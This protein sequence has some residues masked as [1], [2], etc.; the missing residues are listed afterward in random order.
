MGPRMRKAVASFVVLGFLVFYVWAATSLSAWVP[1][2]WW[3]KGLFF[4]IVGT[5]WGLPMFP[6][7]SWAERDPR[8][9][10]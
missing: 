10:S 3:A 1:D 9:G 5:A 6:I 8:R 7:F 2:R 4:G